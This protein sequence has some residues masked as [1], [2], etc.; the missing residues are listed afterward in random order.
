MLIVIK[1]TVHR[2]PI[3][4]IYLKYLWLVQTGDP[5]LATVHGVAKCSTGHSCLYEFATQRSV[6]VHEFE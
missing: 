3:A 4:S 5:L 2:V 1:R 6:L